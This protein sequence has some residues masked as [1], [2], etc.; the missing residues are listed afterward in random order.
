MSKKQ[1]QQRTPNKQPSFKKVTGWLGGLVTGVLL[2]VGAYEYAQYRER[3]LFT[4]EEVQQL[5]ALRIGVGSFWFDEGSSAFATLTST[6]RADGIELIE[7][8]GTPDRKI[9]GGLH[10]KSPDNLFTHESVP[11]PNHRSCY[12]EP[13]E[14]IEERELETWKELVTTQDVDVLVLGEVNSDPKT[15]RLWIGG[16]DGPHSLFLP[17]STRGEINEAT[18][19]V[20]VA[21]LMALPRLMERK[22]ELSPDM[23]ARNQEVVAAIQ[24]LTDALK[25]RGID[26]S[27]RL[28]IE[29]TRARLQSSLLIQGEHLPDQED[30]EDGYWSLRQSNRIAA[31]CGSVAVMYDQDEAIHAVAL[32][33][34]TGSDAWYRRATAAFER[35]Q[36][37]AK[38]GGS[39]GAAEMAEQDINRLIVERG[40]RQKDP[41]QIAEGLRNLEK[42]YDLL[43]FCLSPML[44][45]KLPDV[46]IVLYRQAAK[47]TL[48]EEYSQRAEELW[49]LHSQDFPNGLFERSL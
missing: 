2:A 17:F 44:H 32:T 47:E 35:V 13:L 40:I 41:R 20:K 29:V 15:L 8:P 23:Q 10:Y 49:E 6:M 36:E 18:D 5:S 42:Q 38:K 46:M 16:M 14:A 30:I 4:I 34:G 26:K 7:L 24:S 9:A 37:K 12:P 48:N 28:A 45:I 19:P 31:P 21:I 1:R 11:L 39:C 27:S 22:L 43:P 3:N 33:R 25:W